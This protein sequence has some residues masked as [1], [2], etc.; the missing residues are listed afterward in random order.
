M[1][2]EAPSPLR[3]IAMVAFTLSC[4]GLLLFLW[5][6]FGGSIPLRPQGYRFSVAVPD[7]ANLAP[8]ADVRLAGVNVGKV[9]KKSLTEGGHRTLVQIELESKFAPVPKDTRA[10]LRQK[11]LLGE[12]YVELAPGH[13]SAGMLPDGG[14]LRDSRVEPTVQLDQIFSAF[15]RP[16]RESFRQW[17]A[18]LSKVV[19][20]GRAQDLN[21]A[22]GNLS[23]FAVDGSTLF[24]VLDQQN[25]SVRRLVRNTGE[26]LG[27]VNEREG[28]LRELVQTANQTFAATASRDRALAETIHVFPTFLDETKATLAR[29]EGFSRRTRPLVNDL[30]RPA[31]DLGPTVRDLG[32]LAPDLE[33]LF[34]DIDPL[35]RASRKG[36]PDLRDTLRGAEPVL[37][38]LNPLLDEL[39]PILSFLNFHQVRVTEF[40][41]NAAADLK[42]DYQGAKQ[43]QIAAIDLHSLQRFKTIPE[44]AR[45]NAYLAPNALKRS[46]PLE[47]GQ[48]AGSEAFNCPGG[49]R[50][51]PLDN[52]PPGKEPL[53]PCFLV[54]PSLYSGKQF[55]RIERGRAPK[56]EPPTGTAGTRPA[57]P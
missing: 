29:L 3:I 32:D 20:G 31:D 39:N 57:T 6:S 37:A 18:E 19:E 14:R 42:G 1:V 35:I 48:G 24:R 55:N 21:D 51:N 16:T 26:V 33:G 45:G 2:K 38:G 17:M 34:R 40:I 46:I 49:E 28:A 5:L 13:R 50:R 11:T 15:D 56:V 44:W 22:L 27:A 30:K 43:T 53:A 41:T 8:E 36:V 4:L 47:G 25:R 9:K 7:A 12:T 54:P 10:V 52:P 23:G